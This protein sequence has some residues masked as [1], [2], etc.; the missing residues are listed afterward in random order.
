MRIV[1][2]S[3]CVAAL[4]A[5]CATHEPVSGPTAADDPSMACFGNLLRDVRFEGLYKKIPR[6]AKS[7]TLP[8]LSSTEKPDENGKKDLEEWVSFRLHCLKSG[9]DY[10]AAYAPPGYDATFSWLQIEIA[11]AAAKLYAGEITYGQ[12][13]QKRSALAAETDAKMSI[14]ME[15]HKNALDQQAARQSDNYYRALML[16]RMN[17]P[18]RQPSTSCTTQM[19]GNMAT[20]TCR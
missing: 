3:L 2:F 10:R 13:N 12:F 16:Q 17:N 18:L 20:T 5:G 11:N 9:A 7:A 1:S 6:D 8:Q 14:V 4:L 19:I 15:N